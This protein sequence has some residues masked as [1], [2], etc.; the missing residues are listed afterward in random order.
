VS[1]PAGASLLVA[2]TFLPLGVRVAVFLD[3]AEHQAGAVAAQQLLELGGVAGLLDALAGELGGGGELGLE[4]LAVGDHHHLEAAQ[5][6]VGT[7]LAHQEHHGEALAAALGVPD[8]AAAAVGLAVLAARLA[9]L[10][11]LHGPGDAAELLVAAHQLDGLAA[12]VH[13]Q[14][15]VA[16]DVEQVGPGEHAGDQ[17]L[18]GGEVRHAEIDGHLRLA[19]RRHRLPAQVVGEAGADGADTGLVE[20]AGHQ[21]LAGGEQRRRAL[22]L[23]DLALQK[24][25][26]VVAAQLVHRLADPLRHAAALALHH[27]QRDAVDEQHQ[28][29]D[30]VALGAIV[31]G[32]ALHLELVDHREDV[33]GGLVP[34]DVAQGL[35]AAAVPALQPLYREAVQE[36]LGGL[37]VGLQHL[38][39]RQP[40]DGRHRLIQARLIEP[41]LAV[42]KVDP[43]QPLAQQGL[44]HHLGEALAVGHGGVVHRPG[45]ELPA[46]TDQLVDK[47]LLDIHVLGS[48]HA[49][50]P[51]CCWV[52]DAGGAVCA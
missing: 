52:F 22:V 24:A 29:R 42:A 32:R 17:A 13:E 21:E 45:Q 37:L 26:V 51:R 14:G 30:H 41:G 18:L 23:A 3:G 6:R 19:H 2:L 5:R 44:H 7:Q 1:S 12:D 8:D 46:L 25:L 15:V 10:Q 47:G 49:V 43:A 35:A 34:V 11:A 31:A 16:H 38:A 9:A 33:V 50:T 40:G 48:C 36:Q 28:V 20:V 39:G 4:V 27:H